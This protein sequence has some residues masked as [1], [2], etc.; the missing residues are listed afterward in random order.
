MDVLIFEG[1]T[2]TRRNEKWVD[3]RNMVVHEGLQKD[4]NREYAKQLDPAKLSLSGSLKAVFV[5]IE[6]SFLRE[7][8]RI[9][10]IGY[11]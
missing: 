7:L 10:T 6:R 3:S 11:T 4:L 5:E 8:K 2:Y 1:N 9:I